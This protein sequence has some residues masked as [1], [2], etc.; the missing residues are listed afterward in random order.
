MIKKL[1]EKSEIWFAVVW[2]IAYCVLAS[3]GDNLSVSMGIL[4]SITLPIL[5]VLSAILFLFVKQNGLS[6]ALS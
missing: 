4:K 2:I 6:D 3:V 5:M 1:Y